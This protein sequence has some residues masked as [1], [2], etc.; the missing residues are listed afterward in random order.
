[1]TV[2]KKPGSMVAGLTAR[3]NEAKIADKETDNASAFDEF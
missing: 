1:M 2:R 3:T